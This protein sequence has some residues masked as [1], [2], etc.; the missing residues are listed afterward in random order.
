[1]RRSRIQVEIKNT[2]TRLWPFLSQQCV[3]TSDPVKLASPIKHEPDV[4]MQC[5]TWN[6]PFQVLGEAMFGP[7]S[8]PINSLMLILATRSQPR[9]PND[10]LYSGINTGC[11]SGTTFVP[12]PSLTRSYA[13]E[14]QWTHLP[15]MLSQ[16]GSESLRRG[17]GKK[18]PALSPRWGAGRTQH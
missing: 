6:N 14:N 8:A 5:V 4:N 10:E 17:L 12:F 15:H 18:D 13:S 7:A 9:S 3:P 11:V 16:S 2:E 1:M